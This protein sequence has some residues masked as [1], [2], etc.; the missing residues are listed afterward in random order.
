MPVHR[1]CP[2]AII[3]EHTLSFLKLSDWKYAINSWILLCKETE[4]KSHK[5][6]PIQVFNLGCRLKSL[7]KFLK[8]LMPRIHLVNS[9]LIYLRIKIFKSSPSNPNVSAKIENNC[10]ISVFW[11]IWRVKHHEN[12]ISQNQ[13][14]GKLCWSKEGI[15]LT[16][17]EHRKKCRR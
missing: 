10:S 3:K 8:I 9:D 1:Y 17:K 4:R 12:P 6:L 16:N 2:T 13:N 5:G 11:E 14:G 7:G 15:Y